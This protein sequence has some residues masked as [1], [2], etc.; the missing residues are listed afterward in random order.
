MTRADDQ[1]LD[2]MREQCAL[3]TRL[4]RR[5]RDGYDA[6]EAIRFAI[7]RSMEILGEAANVD[8]ETTRAL[9]RNRLA[10]DLPLPN[11][12]RSPLPPGRSRTGV[13]HRRR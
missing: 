4:V 13:D 8:G 1:R 2:D 3:I 7:E 10:S 11:P 6:D 5:G 12:S 9:P